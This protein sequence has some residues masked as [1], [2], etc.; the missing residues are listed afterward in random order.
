MF[1]VQ[2][3]LGKFFEK[4]EFIEINEYFEKNLTTPEQTS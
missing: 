3:W 4:A 2:R 1:T